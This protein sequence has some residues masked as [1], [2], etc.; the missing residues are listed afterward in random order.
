[1]NEA[2]LVG[3]RPA[4][5]RPMPQPARAEVPDE[6]IDELCSVLF[7]S[8]RRSDQR[9]KGEQYLRG[10]LSAHG[11]K[12]MRNI[13]SYLGGPAAEQSLH[14]FI[15]S[16]TWDWQ[17][18]RE[19]L[20]RHLER[21]T[22]PQAW[23]VRPMA[24]PKAGEHSVGVDRRFAPGLG[25]TVVGQQA[26]GVWLASEHVSAPVNWRL[27]LPDTWLND[28]AKRNR[29]E[30]PEDMGEATPGECATDAVLDVAG[31]GGVA[32]RPVLLDARD[33]DAGAALR[34]F[35]PL[36]VPVLA[37][38]NPATRLV[39]ADHALPGYGGVATPAQ[40]LMESVK[41]LRRPV[42][43]VD[44]AS[45]GGTR[46]TLA[47]A[48][49]VMLPDSA[50]RTQRAGSRCSDLVLLCE[51][52]DPGRWPDQLWLTDQGSV[53]FTSLLRLAKLARR[54]GRDFAEVG[55][56][57]GLRD[58]EG[59]SFRG[60]HRHITLASVAHTAAVLASGLPVARRPVPALSA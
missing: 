38:I 20:A 25:Q 21:T 29:A 8:L 33:W 27:H 50:C 40:R 39:M 37:R 30:I 47:A 19:A 55:E 17:P 9:R 7:T 28:A 51:W 26:Y 6:L 57:V 15:S 41:G 52:S 31:Y 58:Y 35:S 14:H 60:W 43:W 24:I 5:P 2:D 22:R 34:R 11:R 32:R 49:R 12:S 1:M 36:G 4:P 54:V 45:S 23:V 16:S 10:L 42:T 46:T 59:R 13:A 56:Q 18:V 3:R 44:P 53:P 48:V